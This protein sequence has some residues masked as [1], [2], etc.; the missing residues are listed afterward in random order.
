[1][2]NAANVPASPS[3]EPGSV[4]GWISG[5]LIGLLIGG[6]ATAFGMQYYGYE[7]KKPAPANVAPP[8]A[9]TTP[10]ATPGPGG[11]PGGPPMMGMGG[12][13]G[14]MMGGMGGGM[15][16]G[17]AGKRQ[18]TSLV[19]RL[20]LLSRPSLNLRVELTEEQVSKIAAKLAEL[21]AAEKMT[22]DEA[23]AHMEALEALLTEEQRESLNAI[24]LPFGRGGGGGGRGGPGGPGGG[25]PGGPGGGGGPG[26]PGG[27]MM[28][29]MGGG[30]PDENP[31][32]QETNQKRL[33]DLLS[34][35]KPA[36]ESS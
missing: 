30:S 22:A 1:M 27:G 18:L 36:G 13:G 21:D 10:T 12:M 32:T 3:S 5:G 33:R 9:G 23:Q 25:G 4:P 6:G 35:I 28:G 19:G 26:G 34:R 24:S 15:G 2:S 17:N 20:E 29:G 16:G 11:A 8:A 14:G 31:F 7:L